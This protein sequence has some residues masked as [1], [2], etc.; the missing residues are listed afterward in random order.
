MSGINYLINRITTYPITYSNLNKEIQIIDRLLTS[1]GYKHFK[2]RE[3][4]QK[5]KKRIQKETINQTHGKW[6]KFT[7]VGKETKFITK[8]FKEYNIGTAF[9]TKNT[10]ENLLNR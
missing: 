6:A 4:I 1:N 5:K 3:L 8:L 10:V 9:R 2:T 7:Y